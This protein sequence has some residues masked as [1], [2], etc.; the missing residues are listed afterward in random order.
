M[1]QEM[2]EM[3]A[4]NFQANVVKAPLVIDEV[5][6]GAEWIRE[7]S[8]EKNSDNQAGNMDFNEVRMSHNPHTLIM[9]FD[10]SVLEYKATPT[11][12]CTAKK[13]SMGSRVF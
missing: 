6:S 10:F 2:R 4:H 9:T 8:F 5:N 11:W 7:Y 3:D 13:C 1:L 12:S